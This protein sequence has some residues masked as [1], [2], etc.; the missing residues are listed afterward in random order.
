M[1]NGHTYTKT[2]LQRT[3]DGWIIATVTYA[4]DDSGT[5]PYVKTRQ[6]LVAGPFTGPG[7]K[8]RAIRENNGDNT[9]L[10]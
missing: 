2:G 4:Q 10:A 3:A 9:V 6:K 8:L 1:A 5:G 7:A